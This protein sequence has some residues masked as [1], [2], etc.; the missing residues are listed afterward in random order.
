MSKAGLK[1]TIT[2]RGLKV[3]VHLCSVAKVG[4]CVG[5]FYP[6]L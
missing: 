4:A 1:M 3:G 2:P 6:P 5:P